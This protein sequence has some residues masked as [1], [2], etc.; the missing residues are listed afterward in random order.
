MLTYQAIFL[1]ATMKS[2]KKPLAWKKLAL[3]MFSMT[4]KRQEPLTILQTVAITPAQKTAPVFS[5]SNHH[6][7]KKFKMTQLSDGNVHSAKASTQRAET[8]ALDA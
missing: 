1:T 3:V 2:L 4:W 6:S 5:P 8:S 7:S